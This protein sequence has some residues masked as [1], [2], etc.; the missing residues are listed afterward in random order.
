MRYQRR[1]WLQRY[2]IRGLKLTTVRG[3]MSHRKLHFVSSFHS[4]KILILAEMMSQGYVQSDSCCR[5]LPTRTEF[6]SSII[7]IRV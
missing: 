7:N 5:A 2:P 1:M 3:S 4:D 6:T